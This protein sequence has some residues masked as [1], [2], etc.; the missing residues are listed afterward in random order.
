MARALGT[1]D[2]VTTC[3]CCGKAD[4]KCTVEIELDDGQIV[5]Y[6]RVCASRNTGKATK[7][8]NSEIRAEHDRKV[9][10]ART[11]YITSP[12]YIAERARFA[13]RDELARQTGK[14]LLGM[15]AAEFV[16]EARAAAD[17]FSAQ[18]ATS[19]GVSVW[20]VRV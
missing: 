19:Y 12:A 11:E 9:Q 20:E 13:E 17:A 8:I 4:L 2:A 7:V 16:R 1:T 10:L 5:H 6:G 14:R 15:E 18:L 3:D